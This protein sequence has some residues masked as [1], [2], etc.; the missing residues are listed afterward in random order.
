M[1]KNKYIVIFLFLFSFVSFSY[2]QELGVINLRKANFNKTI[3]LDG[4]WE[5]YWNKLLTP[6]DFETQNILPYAYLKVNGVWNEYVEKGQK[7][8]GSGYATYRV[9]VLLLQKGEYTIKLHQILSAYKIWING[10]CLDSVGVVATGKEKYKP[11]VYTNEVNFYSD[12]N[13]LEIIIQVA[14][15][16]HRVGGIQEKIEFGNPNFIETK[17]TNHLLFTFFVLGAELIFALYFFISYFFRKQDWAYIFFSIAIFVSILFDL[18]NGEMILL[19][20]FPEIGFEMQKKIDFFSNYSRLSFFI[21]FL[22]YSF[23]EYKIIDKWLFIAIFATS[24]VLSVIVLFT[25]CIVFSQT[26]LPFMGLGTAAFLYFLYIAIVGFIKKVPFIIY[27]L[28][29]LFLLNL[30]AINDILFNLN[31]INTGY[32]LSTSLLFFFIGHSITLSLKY[33]RS[34]QSVSVLS[35]QFEKYDELLE[36]LMNVASYELNQILDVL[37]SH[38]QA[39]YWELLLEKDFLIVECAKQEKTTIC[40]SLPK[41]I[42]T[43]VS[44]DILQT[45]IKDIGYIVDN[46]SEKAFILFPVFDENILK[47]VFYIEKDKK[48]DKNSIKLLEMP[49]PQLATFID[50]YNFYYNL[51]TLNKNLEK[52]VEKRTNI[53]YEQKKELELKKAQ[54]SEK[55]EELNIAAKMVDDLNQYLDKTKQELSKQNK[56]LEQKRKKLQKQ[57]DILEEKERYIKESIYYAK[58]IHTVF[59]DASCSNFSEYFILKSPKDIVSGDFVTHYVTDDY[60]LIAMIDTTGRNVSAAFLS[61]LIQSIFDGIAQHKPEYINNTALFLKE[62][63]REFIDSLG[64]QLAQRKITDSFDISLAAIEKSTGKVKFSGARQPFV[65]VRN[66][67]YIVIEPD[68]FTIGGHISNFDKEFTIKSFNLREGDMIYMFTDGYYK[69]IG[70]KDKRPLGIQRFLRLLA[71]ISAY[72]AQKQKDILAEKFNIWKGNVKRVDDFFIIGFRFIKP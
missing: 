66:R 14:N 57:R 23:R 43:R 6:K 51:E 3:Y 5:F 70:F 27:S 10:V 42:K 34:T 28:I 22:W 63:R 21:L 47:A 59:F 32:F 50:N 17:T 9:K 38:L 60:I 41:E 64:L 24:S 2:S 72:N 71:E 56:I 69:Q 68:N 12:T 7:I 53:I 39:N 1:Q 35:L 54:L 48:I 52:I 45:A 62:L 33:S 30:G 25:N 61:F 36:K 16:S 44:V 18:V 37:G 19:R 31:I 4:Q 8:G 26:L 67:E 58:K 65:V 13:V 11:F 46:S 15:Y 49:T 20:F 29:G 55:I 40:G